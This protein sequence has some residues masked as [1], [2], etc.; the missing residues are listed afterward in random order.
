MYDT[1]GPGTHP[2]HGCGRPVT[3][4]TTLEVD[5][6][7]HAR[8]GNRPVNLRVAC[9]ACQ[10]AHRGIGVRKNTGASERPT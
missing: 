9:R 8:E 5:H 3:W 2:C 4:G 6:I 7:N 1:I 10:N